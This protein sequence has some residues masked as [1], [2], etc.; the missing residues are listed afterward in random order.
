MAWAINPK[1]NNGYPYVSDFKELYT[2]AWVKGY[3]IPQYMWS[4][5]G[6]HNRGYPF[7]W[8]FAEIKTGEGDTTPDEIP[9]PPEDGTSGKDAPQYNLGDSDT[10]RLNDD[11]GK[12]KTHDPKTGKLLAVA[13]N[14]YVMT[15]GE[16]SQ[17]RNWIANFA[18][19]NII[20]SAIFQKV[21]GGNINDAVVSCKL[22]PL[23]IRK[24]QTGDPVSTMTLNTGLTA[25][26][27]LSLTQVLDFGTVDLGLDKYYDFTNTTYNIYLPF[28]GV[29]TFQPLSRKPFSLEACVDLVA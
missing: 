16:V 23:T 27:P 8:W 4:V 12:I 5:D 20:D 17:L 7:L 28:A 10:H 19:N 13:S 25:A 15:A 29:F 26:T 18:T 14:V 24:S 6:K 11:G 9:Q 22:Y 1:I 2:E 21:F 3:P